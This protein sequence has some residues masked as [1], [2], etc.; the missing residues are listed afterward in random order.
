MAYRFNMDLCL[1]ESEKRLLKKQQ[2]YLNRVREDAEQEGHGVMGS[3]IANT[4]AHESPMLAG[5][6]SRTPE[7]AYR[8]FDQVSKIEVNPMGEFSTWTRVIQNDRSANIA[9]MTYEYR[10]V[11]NM[12]DIAQ[13]SMTGQQGIK[14]DHTAVEYGGTIL[15]FHDAGFGR[16]F[17]EIE[18]MR[19]EGYDA[20]VDDSREAGLVLRRKVNDYLWNGSDITYKGLSWGGIK[21]DASVVQ[22]TYS[23]SLVTG[24]GPEVRET[25][26]GLRD[27][28]MI[29]NNCSEMLDLAVSQEIMSAWEEEYTTQTTGFGTIYDWVLKL[30]NIN[31]VYIDPAL[32]GEEVAFFYF[33]LDG[34]H[35]I[36][37]MAESTFPEARL[38]WNSDY[39][40]AKVLGQ[41]FNNKNSFSGK[42][43]SLYAV[44]V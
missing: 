37:K 13:T 2:M 39:N 23:A 7:D 24:T 14:M 19:S 35:S 26:R 34:F 28:L 25:I 27:N 15:P 29:T 1:S 43:C 22:T 33:G 16:N 11:S 36:T 4:L 20:L 38:R 31:S 5:N 17:L 12:E 32:S 6:A 3:L 9:K 8:E 18:A 30:N 41:G 42:S 40:F 44:K 21:S 10:K